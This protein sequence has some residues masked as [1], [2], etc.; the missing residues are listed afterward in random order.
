MRQL[1]LEWWLAFLIFFICI[2]FYSACSSRSSRTIE[3]SQQQNT[4]EPPRETKANTSVSPESNAPQIAFETVSAD[5]K[6]A[7]F[8]GVSFVY[9]ASLFP[10]VRAET[11]PANPLECEDCK[12]DS[13]YPQHIRFCFSKKHVS[14]EDPS[15]CYP[16]L[17]VFRIDEF[18]E[19][20]TIS[21]RMVEEVDEDIGRL[22]N[23][24]SKKSI[25]YRDEIPYLDYFDGGRAFQ[26]HVKRIEFQNG[27]GVLV[28][29]EYNVDLADYITNEELAYLFQGLTND[30]KYSVR[31]WFPVS[32]I[33][34]P[35]DSY[36]IPEPLNRVSRV[37]ADSKAYEMYRMRMGR[38]LDALS[39]DKYQP[40][41]TEIENLVRS[42]RIEDS[43]N[44]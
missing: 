42:I 40:A 33:S 14:K 5:E 18:R 37:K 32:C 27:T 17:V 43:I 15:H 10:E 6:R 8:A 34:F 1:R 24:L 26:A 28:L 16:E 2:I 22:E 44:K 13:N 21:K 20:F 12:V 25:S 38:K 41:L 3:Q 19:A 36:Q 4:S 30:G 11:V 29:T 7:S 39:P 31:A 23:L 35:K 9:S